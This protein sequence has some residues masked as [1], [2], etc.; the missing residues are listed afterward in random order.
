MSSAYDDRPLSELFRED[1]RHIAAREADR[2][3]AMHRANFAAHQLIA[4]KARHQDIKE[5]EL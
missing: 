5:I 2:I 3:L 1:H 4:K